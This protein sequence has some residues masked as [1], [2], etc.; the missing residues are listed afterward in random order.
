MTRTFWEHG[1]AL[2]CWLVAGF[3]LMFAAGGL[4]A[5]DAGAGWF[6]WLVSA[7]Q[8]DASAFDAAGLRSTLAIMGAVMF[9]WGW[10]LIAVYRAVGADARVWRGLSWAIMGWFGVDSALSIITG[11]PGNAVT[12]SLFLA[13]Y[14]LPAF[15]LGLFRRERA[16]RSPG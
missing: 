15:R 5:T 14:L 11:I 4:A 16:S 3:G 13:L 8:L 1:L 9:G 10:S 6:Y 2:W 7:G 12:N